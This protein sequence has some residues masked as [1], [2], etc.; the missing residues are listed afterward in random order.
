M[1]RI[2]RTRT[3]CEGQSARSELGVTARAFTVP[4]P[5]CTAWSMKKRSPVRAGTL[6]SS[7]LVSTFTFGPP[8]YR[9]TS[10]R[11]GSATVKSVYIGSKAWMTARDGLWGPN[12]PPD[13][14]QIGFR[15]GEVGV[16]RVQALNDDK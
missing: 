4:K 6:S 3:N 13:Q 8:R 12:I 15:H 11:S 14:R 5:G 16:Y 2:R 7:D 9:R 1:S 10:G